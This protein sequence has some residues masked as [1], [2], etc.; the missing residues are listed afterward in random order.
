MT[1][2]A[3]SEHHTD[4]RLRT[5]LL[6]IHTSAANFYARRL[7]GSWAQTYL[8]ERVGSINALIWRPGYAPGRWTSL[9]Q[10]LR[11]QGHH[12]EAIEASGLALRIRTGRLVDRFRDRLVFPMLDDQGHP[13]A[14]VGRHHP[15]L[16]GSSGSPKYLNSPQ[17]PLYTK[18]QHLFGLSHAQPALRSGALPVIVEGPLDAIAVTHH[19][20]GQAVGVALLGTALTSEQVDALHRLVHLDIRPVVL[21]TD[22]DAAGRAAAAH[23][24][25]LLAARG[26]DPLVAA[27]PDD[28]DPAGYIAQA[29]AAAFTD[30]VTTR[31]RPLSQQLIADVAGGYA[32][33]PARRT[34]DRVAAARAGARIV[35]QLTPNPDHRWE[36]DIRYLAEIT[37]VQVSTARA[38]VVD[39][40]T[41]GSDNPDPALAAAA[42]AHAD[43]SR[44]TP[45]SGLAAPGF[46][47]GDLSGSHR[48]PRAPTSSRSPHR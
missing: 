26:A 47:P 41:A 27:L 48:P 21:A 31:A 1:R 44:T 34:E 23:A 4:D 20:G 38:V 42:A 9:T 35:G 25:G 45:I 14:F 7:T 2:P 46:H 10:H 18:G 43:S 19:T 12:D 37:G 17:T 15:R 24:F 6:A 28:Q 16:D 13:I 5:E 39:A 8:I 33:R 40:G 3:A 29:G 30:A 36:R 32:D 22:C 11:R